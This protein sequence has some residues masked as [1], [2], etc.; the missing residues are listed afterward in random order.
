MTVNIDQKIVGYKVLGPAEAQEQQATGLE[1]EQM[2][3][4][5]ERPQVLKGSTYK[6]KTPMSEHAIYV[7]IN[8]ILLNPGHGP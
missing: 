3:E 4:A 7:T 1:V 2:N 8:D 6:I 5:L